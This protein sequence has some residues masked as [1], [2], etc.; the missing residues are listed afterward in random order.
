MA[1]AND[2]LDKLLQKARKAIADRDWDK[3]KQMYLQALGLKSDN[4]DV[5]YGLATVF[6]QLRELTSAAHHFKEVTRLDPLRAGAYINLGAVQNLLQQY[7][8][9]V[10]VLRRGL[11]LDSAR[12]EGYYNLGVVYRNLGQD[13]LAMQA[14][15]EALRLNPRMADAQLNLA[16]LLFGRQNFRQAMQHYEEALK[17][18]PNWAKAIDGITQTREALDVDK[19]SAPVPIAGKRIDSTAQVDPDT[20]GVFLVHL[21]Q[22]T[23]ESEESGRALHQ[24]LEREI[25]PA[26]KE[27]SAALL[28]PHGLRT[29][30]EESVAKFEAAVDRMRNTY[31]QMQNRLAHLQ[32]LESQFPQQ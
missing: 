12:V 13:D 15:R 29:E 18:R 20:H 17:L 26:I 25:E 19:K 23:I 3:A 32:K 4:P 1:A 9:A 6:F 14:Y 27:L 2:A 28:Q 8:E 11:Q 21:H 30:L 7:D 10:T 22:V 24:I 31:Q 5:H 16:N